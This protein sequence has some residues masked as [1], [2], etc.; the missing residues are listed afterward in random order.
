MLSNNGSYVNG[1]W[2]VQESSEQIQFPRPVTIFAAV[3]AIVFS[4]VGVLG[5][6]SLLLNFA[7]SRYIVKRDKIRFIQTR[8]PSVHFRSPSVFVANYK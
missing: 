5:N 7:L 3:C 2:L 1:Q 8:A 4:I 6:S